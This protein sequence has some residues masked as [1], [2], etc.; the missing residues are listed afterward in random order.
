MSHPASNLSISPS[1]VSCSELFELATTVPAA[2][3]VRRSI[4]QDNTLNPEDM[5]SYRGAEDS[6][7]EFEPSKL[8][9]IGQLTVE[10]R[11]MPGVHIVLPERKHFAV[12][13]AYKHNPWWD[14]VSKI[15]ITSNIAYLTFNKQRFAI[16]EPWAN[17]RILA[18]GMRKSVVFHIYARTTNVGCINVASKPQK[19]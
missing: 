18:I 15:A 5:A 4:V 1:S 19:Y 17:S 8:I 16:L 3:R 7:A 13:L 6:L 11:S 2:R 12:E 14:G 10:A 9:C